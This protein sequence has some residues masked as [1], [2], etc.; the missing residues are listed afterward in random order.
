MW[1]KT[2]KPN[3]RSSCIGVDPNRNWDA[4]FGGTEHKVYIHVIWLREKTPAKRCFNVCSDL[5]ALVLAI[6]LARRRTAGRALT[7]SLRSRQSLTLSSLT[8]TWKP[9][10]PSTA[11][12]RCSSTRT[13]T[14]ELPAR[15]RRS[16]WDLHTSFSFRGKNNNL[17]MFP[18]MFR[19]H[20]LAK[21]AITDLSSLYKTQYRYGSI[22]NTICTY[23]RKRTLV[24]MFSG[25]DGFIPVTRK[26]QD[27]SLK[28]QK[29]KK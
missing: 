27:F 2:R 17:I 7:P 28:L 5:Q 6:A 29:P 3:P 9:L 4:G 1:R 20:E 24:T 23:K 18:F 26:T 13:A 14:P 8:A 19:Q 10:C 16:W 15:T 12:L 11:T 25:P 21:K 22:I